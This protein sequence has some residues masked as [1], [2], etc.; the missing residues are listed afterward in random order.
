MFCNTPKLLVLYSKSHARVQKSIHF[1]KIF[2][3]LLF[4]NKLYY[5][6]FTESA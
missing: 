5:D 4:Y 1:Y 2:S 3:N 6:T